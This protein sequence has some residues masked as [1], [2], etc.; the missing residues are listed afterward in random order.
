MTNRRID[1]ILDKQDT[2]IEIATGMDMKL[3]EIHRHVFYVL[4]EIDTT[5][6]YWIF[7]SRENK[8]LTTQF[9][10]FAAYLHH[11][12]TMITAGGRDSIYVSKD[13]G[14]VED[15][16][17][18]A[19][20]KSECYPTWQMVDHSGVFHSS[21]LRQLP[22]TLFDSSS[23]FAYWLC[24]VAK[25]GRPQ[26]L[27]CYR[28]YLPNPTYHSMAM[29]RSQTYQF[30]ARHYKKRWLWIL[31]L[32]HSIYEKRFAV[33]AFAKALPTSKYEIA[34]DF[35]TLEKTK[36]DS[37]QTEFKVTVLI[38]TMGRADY[39][40]QVLQ[41]LSEQEV[42]PQKIVIVEQ[43]PD[44][45]AH[46]A[47]DYLQTE[48]WPFEIAHH[49]THQTGACNARNKGL[50]QIDNGWVLF[51]DDDVRCAPDFIAKLHN[52]CISTGT[53]ALTFACLQQGEVE[54]MKA[55][56]QWESFGSGCS[57][58]HSDITKKLRFDMA[59]EHGYGED[60][61]YG[62]QIRH[63]GYDILYAPQIQVLHLKA[64]VGGFRQPHIFAW[65]NTTPAPKP[66][67][68]I[69]YHRQ[70]NYTDKQLLG[71]KLVLFLKAYR[72]AAS[73]NLIGFYKEVEA[74]WQASKRWAATL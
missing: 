39:L 43:N 51:F 28:I 46:S 15:G 33:L 45:S 53:K 49:F 56:K 52:A 38:P 1:I 9:S 32:A 3:P 65:H 5:S 58:V 36:I 30:V 70:K 12:N 22:A 61:D 64:P 31:F 47:L 13:I 21:L 59:L 55:F 26:G 18:L 37:S 73:L 41:D 71:Y 66:S 48:S 14:Y 20:G 10:K 6:D 40:Y 50:E 34:L 68:Q 11:S 67:P 4:R 16:P 42:L 35:D 7:F 69:M 8:E 27:C 62:M 72:R 24:S 54:T 63:A 29:T 25:I 19:T 17:Y 23:S 60:V 74:K 44:V 2:V 57:L